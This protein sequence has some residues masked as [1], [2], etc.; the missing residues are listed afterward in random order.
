VKSGGSFV[1]DE[2]DQIGFAKKGGGENINFS[3]AV[4]EEFDDVFSAGV[5]GCAE[6]GFPVAVT[7]VEGGVKDGG[8]SV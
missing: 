6:S 4:E 8:I 2:F 5:G 3:A 1:E 7:P